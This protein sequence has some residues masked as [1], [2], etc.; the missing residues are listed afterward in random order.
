MGWQADRWAAGAS[1]EVSRRFEM[2]D[3]Y[4]ELRLD[5]R[6]SDAI[7]AYA[8]IGATPNADFRPEWQIGAGGAAR[9]QSGPHATVLTLDARQARYRAGDIQTLNPG[10]EQYVAGGRAWLTARW[11][12]IFDEKG[13]H[14]SGWLGRGDVQPRE[15]LRLFAGIA[16][17]PDV[18][19][20]IVVDTTSVF[21]GLSYDLD[22]GTS[23]RISLAHEDRP[24]DG[25]RSQ[26]ALGL[27]Y[28]F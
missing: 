14:R 9:L 26:L 28:R 27:G 16:S 11:I 3:V 1:L 2:T 23:V 12:N 24:G 5:R 15:D 20:G 13:R 6:F 22:A 8:S 17:A 18:S 21:G 7:S 19:E 4:G 10:I 25:D